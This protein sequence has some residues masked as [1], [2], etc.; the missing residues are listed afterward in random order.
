MN[1]AMSSK[2]ELNA[3]S[4]Q[5]SWPP[6]P[7]ELLVTIAIAVILGVVLLTP[8]QWASDGDMIVPVSVL[9]FDIES[10]TPIANA[11][12]GLFRAP[13]RNSDSFLEVFQGR[14]TPE[15]LDREA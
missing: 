8:T 4:A 7:L 12:V 5:R 15:I 6:T 3:R 11:K 9:A 2:S 13:P 14:F 1:S 10:A